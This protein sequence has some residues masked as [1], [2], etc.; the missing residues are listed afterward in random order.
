MFTK[1]RF[2]SQKNPQRYKNLINIIPCKVENFLLDIVEIYS[3][4]QA[5]SKDKNSVICAEF[6]IG[7]NLN[8]P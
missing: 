3:S 1:G 6:Q 5:F 7:Y 4:H 2:S 8:L